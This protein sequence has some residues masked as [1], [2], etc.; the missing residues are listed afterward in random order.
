MKGTA[1]VNLLPEGLIL[2]EMNLPQYSFV[3]QRDGC[4]DCD[5]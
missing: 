5:C 4:P 3:P 1:V 2:S